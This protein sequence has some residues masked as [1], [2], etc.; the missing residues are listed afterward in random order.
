MTT[1]TAGM[2]LLAPVW[3]H[4]TTMQPVRAQGAYFYDAD[5]NSYLDFTCG[6]GVTNTGH[7]HPQVVQAIQEQAGQLHELA[8]E[9]DR[10]DEADFVVG[11]PQGKCEGDQERAALQCGHA[12]AG[13]AIDG[14]Q[15]HRAR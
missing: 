11:G 5:G 8:G 12:H 2:D 9:G 4:L 15:A 6:I 14:E 13:D 1:Q 3:T 10:C 7:C